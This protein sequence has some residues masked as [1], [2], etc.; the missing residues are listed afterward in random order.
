MADV[1]YGANG[2]FNRKTAMSGRVNCENSTFGDPVQGRCT[3][4]ATSSPLVGP[5]GYTYAVPEGAH[6][7][8]SGLAD[9]AYGDRGKFNRKTGVNG[10]IDC[11]NA[12]FGNPD[13]GVQKACYILPTSARPDSPTPAPKVCTS[14]STGP[15]TS[16][17]ATAACSPQDRRE[18]RHRLHQR[19]VR[20]PRPRRAEA[21]LIKAVASGPPPAGPSGFTY[22]ASEGSHFTISGTADVAY[23]ANG[24]FI[25]KTRL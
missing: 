23:G 5:A 4:L 18:R 22:A 2:K 3:S 7:S 6:I 11:T 1:A 19:R 8:F 9:V 24:F 16:P 15:P 14:P 17:T 25:L 12:V 21:V 13:P 20:Q 10:G